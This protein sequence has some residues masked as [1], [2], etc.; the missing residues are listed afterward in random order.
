[1]KARVLIR[2]KQSILD[3]QGASVKRALEGLGFPEV[4]DVRVGKV[5]DLDLD[6]EGADTARRRIDEMCARL[7]VNPVIE[8]FIVEVGE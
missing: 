6:G 1:M 7:L 8:D 2:L 4:R 5:V 3:A